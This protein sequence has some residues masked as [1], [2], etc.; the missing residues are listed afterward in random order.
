M[1]SSL[2]QALSIPTIQKIIPVYE[3]EATVK[4]LYKVFCENQLKAFKYITEKVCAVTDPILETEEADPK[5]MYDLAIQ[6]AVSSNVFKMLS[7]DI[8]AIKHVD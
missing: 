4:D 8:T 7:E 5:R 3:D 1:I 6:I 2:K